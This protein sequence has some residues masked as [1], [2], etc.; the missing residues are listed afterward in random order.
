[1]S[2]HLHFLLRGLHMP[3]KPADRRL[4]S[5][6]DVARLAGVSQSAVSR[7]F[8]SGASVS[9]ETRE[10][11]EKA[12][13]KLGYVPNRIPKIMQTS[14]SS[15]IAI[16][17]GPLENPAL[18]NI[19]EALTKRLQLAGLQVLIVQ[20]DSRY[21]LDS[22][23]DRL[24]Q[25]RVD[26]I[27]SALSVTSKEAVAALERARIPV[28]SFDT[29]L[30]GEFSYLSSV[31]SN[32]F[33]AS[34][35]VANLLIERGADKFLFMDGPENSPVSQQRLA[36]FAAGLSGAGARGPDVLRGNFRYEDAL[37]VIVGEFERGGRPNGIFCAN[38]L[39][40]LGVLDALR[41]KI[42]LRVPEDVMVVG[43]DDIPQAS[44][45]SYSLTTCRP[46]V[47]QLVDQAMIRLGVGD[48]KLDDRTELVPVLLVERQTTLPP[49][50]KF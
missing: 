32:N 50:A 36:G 39:M 5:S 31:S 48:Q 17:V 43:F 19:L 25:Y 49:A 40:A 42:G 45:L 27:A 35:S 1:M 44:W 37:N 9:Q 20:V 33:S 6:T 28:V 24:L 4:P 21:S 30:T 15:L 22:A 8:T 26:A 23:V 47:E 34:E 12:A 16:V 10:K 2:S 18:A 41:L 29:R 13:K 14:S 3:I 11:V 38:D 7:T 46:N